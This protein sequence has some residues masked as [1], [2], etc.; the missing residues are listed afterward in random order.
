VGGGGEFDQR[1]ASAA[2]RRGEGGN[3]VIFSPLGRV[4]FNGPTGLFFSILTDV[5]MIEKIN[6]TRRGKKVI[7]HHWAEWALM[8]RLVFFFFYFG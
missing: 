6:L 7:F 5:V 2:E 1:G 3:K 8:G 4:G